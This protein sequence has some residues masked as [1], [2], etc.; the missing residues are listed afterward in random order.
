[1]IGAGLKAYTMVSSP[2]EEAEAL[3]I[4]AQGFVKREMWRPALTAYKESL[5]IAENAER[6]RHL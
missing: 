5:K 1:M 6:P 4:T 3:D 2:A